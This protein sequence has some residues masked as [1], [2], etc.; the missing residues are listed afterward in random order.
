[1][2]ALFATFLLLSLV[3]AGAVASV[4]GADTAVT[5]VRFVLLGDDTYAAFSDA[6]GSRP[7]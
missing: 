2:P 4:A 6:L 7:C 5:E 1:M 3:L